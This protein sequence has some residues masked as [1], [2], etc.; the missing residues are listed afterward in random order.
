MRTIVLPFTL[1]AL[2]ACGDG[3]TGPA[4]LGGTWTLRT[5]ADAPLPV[6]LS[7]QQANYPG[8]STATTMRTYYD[9]AHLAVIPGERADTLRFFLRREY[10]T[11]GGS[12][13]APIQLREGTLVAVCTG[14][15]EIVLFGGGSCNSAR[16]PLARSGDTLTFSASPGPQGTPDFVSVPYRFVRRGR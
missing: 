3:G 13:L 4:P 6:L 8:T 15:T 12:R 1:L 2:A 10:V 5:V 9:S 11:S 16:V 14:D 7:T